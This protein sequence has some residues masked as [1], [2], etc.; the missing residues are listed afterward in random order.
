MLEEQEFKIRFTNRSSKTITVRLEP[1]LEEKI[2]KKE[3]SLTI[4]AK[5]PKEAIVDIEYEVNK[6]TMYG[7]T[8]SICEL[9]DTE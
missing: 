8:G 5:G 6:I 9:S 7:W 4:K 1:W 2:L 3:E